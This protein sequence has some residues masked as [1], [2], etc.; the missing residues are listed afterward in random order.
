MINQISI[1]KKKL[2]LAF[3]MLGRRL[4]NISSY[5]LIL[6]CHCLSKISFNGSTLKHPRALFCYNQAPKNPKCQTLLVRKLSNPFGTYSW[7]QN[8]V[9][10]MVECTS[11]PLGHITMK[12]GQQTTLFP[13][14]TQCEHVLVK[15]LTNTSS[16][17]T[18]IYVALHILTKLT[19]IYQMVRIFSQKL[20]SNVLVICYKL[21]NVHVGFLWLIKCITP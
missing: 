11:Y 10:K 6:S 5:Y 17:L 3:V 18:K 2:Q 14:L 19:P 4:F 1:Y 21:G 13:I 16:H 8:V 12:L 20:G 7:P 9:Q 15:I